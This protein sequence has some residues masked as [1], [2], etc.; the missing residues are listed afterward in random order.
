MIGR[1]SYIQAANGVFK[2]KLA[3]YKSHSMDNP[4]CFGSATTLLSKLRGWSNTTETR[5]GAHAIDLMICILK[6]CIQSLL[7]E[8]NFALFSMT[9]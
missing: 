5:V 1:S 7:L 4:Y 9:Y 3:A 6:S 2:I 8:H